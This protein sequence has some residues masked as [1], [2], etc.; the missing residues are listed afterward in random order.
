MKKYICS[1]CGYGHEGATAPARCP[2]CG[3]SAAKFKLQD[4][5]T[6]AWADGHVVGSAANVDARDH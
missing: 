6:L 2:Q 4:D 5:M 3:A 1:V